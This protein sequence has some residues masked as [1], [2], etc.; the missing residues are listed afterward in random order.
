MQ[1]PMVAN[2]LPH[3]AQAS[4]MPQMHSPHVNPQAQVASHTNMPM[5]THPQNPSQSMIASQQQQPHLHPQQ[6]QHMVQQQPNQQ[7][8]Q[9]EYGFQANHQAYPNV[10]Q[11]PTQTGQPGDMMLQQHQQNMYGN[12][13]MYAA[14][15]QQPPQYMNQQ[16][17]GM[18]PQRGM[19]NINYAGANPGKLNK[20]NIFYGNGDLKAN[21]FWI[22]IEKFQ[23][24][25]HYDQKPK[26]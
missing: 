24:S 11:Q 3:P 12:Q 19:P 14:Q 9:A 15:Q 16:P 1:N 4:P 20:K 25:K 26:I 10:Y 22:R 2:Q 8:P 21:R 13:P 18:Q 23:P 17:Y 5:Q 6:Q 7:L